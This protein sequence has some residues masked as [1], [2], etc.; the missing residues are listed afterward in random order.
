VQPE[1]HHSAC[2]QQAAL[3]RHSSVKSRFSS[4]PNTSSALLLEEVTQRYVLH[5]C[6]DLQ[7][8]TSAIAVSAMLATEQLFDGPAALTAAAAAAAG[9]SGQCTYL[10]R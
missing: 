7:Q 6:T 10:C 8:S 1:F 9:L 5:G 4:R 2:K 3:R